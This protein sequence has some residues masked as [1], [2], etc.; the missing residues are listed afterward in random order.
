MEMNKYAKWMS[1]NNATIQVS[2]FNRA[3][4]V[5]KV[6]YIYD[7]RNGEKWVQAEGN[8]PDEAVVAAIDAAN[9]APRPLYAEPSEENIVLRQ[10]IEALKTELALAKS[11]GKPTQ[12]RASVMEEIEE[13]SGPSVTV[14]DAIAKSGRK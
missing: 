12:N 2:G 6:A 14:K 10:K 3:G 1:E 11:G 5:G 8:D 9:K 4:K 13:D 7:L